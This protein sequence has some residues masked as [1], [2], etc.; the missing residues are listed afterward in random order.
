MR[1]ASFS[2]VLALILLVAVISS[3]TASNQLNANAIEETELIIEE[4]AR[5][6]QKQELLIEKISEKTAE[7]VNAFVEEEI[8][9]NCTAIWKCI[10]DSYRGMQHS[11]CTWGIIEKCDKSC[12]NGLCIE[13]KLCDPLLFSCDGNSVV[14]CDETGLIYNLEKNCV[15]GCS[16]G[17]CLGIDNSTIPLT[18][19]K[20]I[21]SDEIRISTGDIIVLIGIMAPEND[22]LRSEARN[23]LKELILD[24]EISIEKDQVT[25]SEEN[26]LLR[27]VFLDGNNINALLISEGLASL[28]V[29]EPNVKYKSELEQAYQSCLVAK[30]N[31]CFVPD[32]VTNSSKSENKT[33]STESIEIIDECK[34]ECLQLNVH[35][36]AEGNDCS[37]LNDE[38]VT[39]Q[40]SCDNRCQIKD[41]DLKDDS[42]RIPYKFPDI[43][44]NRSNQIKIF[45][46][47]GTNT[48]I[49]LYWCSKGQ[50]C[51][52]IWNNDKDSVLLYDKN[53]IL[54]INYTY[55]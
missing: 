38:Y 34:K 2:V 3:C 50:P 21:N 1:W 44:I 15:Y 55:S 52:A 7:E 5:D 31:L 26:N 6:S 19:N 9:L 17:K 11:D 41:W 22:P 43:G 42:D 24:K 23:R 48:D 32:N 18:V 8:E 54:V 45:T 10:N 51:N 49:D 13:P 14:M 53:N 30:K 4:T 33:N 46:G 16:K 12:D 37:N 28:N 25:R 36:D 20:V 47:C 29:A 27:Y 40:N 39:L 35:Y